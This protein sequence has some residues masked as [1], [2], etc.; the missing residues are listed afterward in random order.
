VTPE[1]LQDVVRTAVSGAVGRGVLAVEVPDEVVVERPK[2]REH[3]DYATNIAL[4][5]AK[6]AGRP[7]REVA[8][9]LAGELRALDAVS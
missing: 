9:L 7:P 6:A 5:L 2:N 3:G 4:R 1:Q 8:E